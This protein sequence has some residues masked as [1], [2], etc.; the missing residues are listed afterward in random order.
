MKRLMKS[1]G[2][3]VCLALAVAMLWSRPMPAHHS[4]AHFDM[5]RTVAVT[6]KV[7]KWVWANPHSWVYMDVT[8]ADGTVQSWAFECSSPNMMI[9]WGW[10]YADIKIGDTLTI[11]THPA[12][13]GSSQGSVYAVF[14]PDGRV[15]ADP[16]GRRV[17]GDELAQGPPS[18]PTKPTGEP[19]R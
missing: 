16:M 19:Y 11:D 6:G 9:R 17:S 4:F 1:S 5:A 12:R 14:L 7:T 15:L 3:A 2:A 13:D 10:R 18:L 8:R